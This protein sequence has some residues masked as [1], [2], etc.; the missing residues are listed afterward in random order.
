MIGLDTNILLRYLTKDDTAQTGLVYELIDDGIIKGE[1]FYI[2]T[3]VVCEI[4]WVLSRIYKFS[5]SQIVTVLEALLDT[6]GLIIHEEDSVAESVE[7]YRNSKMD[8]SDI[9]IAVTNR[10]AG[11]SYTA[12]FDKKAAALKDFNI[13]E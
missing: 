2:N 8:F 13:L 1:I 10:N 5:K 3:I 6:D 4:I 12:T 11:V 7:I 9:L